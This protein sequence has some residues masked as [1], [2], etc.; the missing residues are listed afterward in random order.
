[1][2]SLAPHMI[3]EIPDEIPEQKASTKSSPLLVVASPNQTKVDIRSHINQNLH[4]ASSFTMKTL[5]FIIHHVMETLYL[6]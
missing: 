1:M 4:M 6:I 2:Q 5:V 3:S